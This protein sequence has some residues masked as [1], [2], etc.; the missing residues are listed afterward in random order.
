MILEI[1][2]RAN[3][4]FRVGAV[5]YL[6]FLV[7]FSVAGELM[8]MSTWLPFSI[9]VGLQLLTIP[10]ALALP[11]TLRATKDQASE[12]PDATERGSSDTD[13]S[14]GSTD[15]NSITKERDGTGWFGAFVDHLRK[16]ISTDFAF[17]KDGGPYSLHCHS[18]F[19]KLSTALTTSTS[20]MFQ[21]GSVGQ[22]QRPISY[23]HSKPRLRSSS[24]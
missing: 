15:P 3:V 8:E 6:C 17:L 7:G 21:S 24:C 12:L 18:P 19:G 9:A 2:A 23:T 1:C 20:S 10:A 4:F 16:F 14:P 22:L 11:E 5:S 13:S